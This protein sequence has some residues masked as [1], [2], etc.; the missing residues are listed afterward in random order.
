MFRVK[1]ELRKK[2]ATFTFYFAKKKKDSRISDINWV[3]LTSLM[4]DERVV[5]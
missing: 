4:R 1:V 3:E 5:S 2:M